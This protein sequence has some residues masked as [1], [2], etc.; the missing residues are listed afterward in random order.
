MSN[1]ELRSRAK[2]LLEGR[3]SSVIIYTIVSGI[4]AGILE[5]IS[6]FFGP[7]ID[8]TSFPFREV[9][10][11]NPFLAQVFSIAASVVAVLLAISTIN[12]FI[13]VT[14]GEEIVIEK[15]LMFGFKLDPIRT[16]VANVVVGIYVF[17]WTLLLVIPG[18]MKAYSY[19]MT[20]YLLVVD[21]LSGTE[22][23]TRSKQLMHG[24][25]MQLFMLDLSYIPQ[26]LLGIFTLGIL[27]LWIVPK[28][29]TARILFFQHLTES[30]PAETQF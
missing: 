2:E 9:D 22:S 12:V 21:E 13:K 28:H 7:T 26:Y 15:D 29:N 8:Y 10:P 20:N 18:F 16:I 5:G 23:I 17:L 25:R 27:W 24:H 1:Y 14:K 30:A 6:Q 4:L 3:Y 19:S 11:G